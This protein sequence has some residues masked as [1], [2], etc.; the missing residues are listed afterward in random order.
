MIKRESKCNG[1]A[2]CVRCGR[3][4]RHETLVFCDGCGTIIEDE[5]YEI[6]GKHYCDECILNMFYRFDASEIDE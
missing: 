3:K 4:H 2:E 1:C 5:V 6:D